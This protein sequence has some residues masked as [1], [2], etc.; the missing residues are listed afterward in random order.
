MGVKSTKFI[1]WPHLIKQMEGR[2]VV[3]HSFL[4]QNHVRVQEGEQCLEGFLF[5]KPPKPANIHGDN[6]HGSTYSAGDSTLISCGE[7]MDLVASL[8]LVKRGL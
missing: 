2:I 4:Y 5:G 8:I 6:P 7:F 1:A 3:T